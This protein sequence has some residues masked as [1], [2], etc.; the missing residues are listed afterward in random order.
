MKSQEIDINKLYSGLLIDND[1][2]QLG[3]IRNKPNIF[4]TLGVK[5][6]EIRHSNFLA[7]LLDPNGNHGLE[8]Y[9]LKRFL[10]NIFKDVKSQ[11]KVIDIHNLLKQNVIIHRERF[12]ID[13]LIEFENTIIIIENKINA[14][15]GFGQLKRYREVVSE[16]YSD[17]KKIECVFLTK[18]GYESSIPEHYITTS[19]N[20]IRIILED[21]ILYNADNLNQHTKIYISDYIDNL[22][23]NILQMDPANKLA[24]KIYLNHKDLFDFIYS[25]RPNAVEYVKKSFNEFLEKDGYVIG[26]KAPHFTRFITREIKE[27]LLPDKSKRTPWYLGEVLLIELI[28]RNEDRKIEFKI[29]ISPAKKELNEF[30]VSLLKSDDFIN[31][32]DGDWKVFNTDFIDFDF[33]LFD[34]EGYVD[35]KYKEIIDL[36]LQLINKLNHLIVSHAEDLRKFYP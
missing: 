23:K 13:L 15:E 34:D 35:Q 16:N 17:R 32:H 26:S 5:S 4:E 7:W 9:F 3:L 27:I 24:E 14:V 12:Y 11:I 19:Y 31:D 20:D 1:F 28:Y 33:S 25:N 18:D 36:K 8:N 6:Y 10:I 2:E 29:A 30:L 21:V 22:K